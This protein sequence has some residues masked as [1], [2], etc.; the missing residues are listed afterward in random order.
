M[1]ILS[2]LE[3]KEASSQKQEPKLKLIYSNHPGLS[4]R[5][6]LGQPDLIGATKQEIVMYFETLWEKTG[7]PC[8]KP[9]LP[10]Q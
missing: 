7:H 10:R 6:K 2:C 5:D 4:K 3:V 1:E 8:W 9:R